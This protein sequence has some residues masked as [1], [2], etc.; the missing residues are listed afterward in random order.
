MSMSM[1]SKK[2]EVLEDLVKKN[3]TNYEW[4]KEIWIIYV[5]E[6]LTNQIEIMSRRKLGVIYVSQYE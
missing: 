4:R 3:E 6:D 2:I 1:S 5:F